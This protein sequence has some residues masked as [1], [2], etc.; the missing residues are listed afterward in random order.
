MSN[1]GD[2]A[3]GPW[4]LI[5]RFFLSLPATPPSI[6]AE[7]WADERLDPG[8]RSLWV[9]MSNQDRRHSV[10]V[11]KR[12]LAVR[13]GAT[14]AEVAGA[15]LHDVGKIDAQLGTFERVVATLVGP[16]TQRYRSYHDHEAIGADLVESVGA[17]PV[18]V[19]LVAGHGPAFD[20]LEAVDY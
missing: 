1:W 12:F 4:H 14:R 9:R 7:L 11:A 18:T 2:I 15:L 16:R 3:G 8:E 5:R 6:E 13:P 10:A 17:D 20:D 19:D